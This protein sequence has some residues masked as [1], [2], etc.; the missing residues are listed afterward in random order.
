MES[1]FP[2]IEEKIIKFWKDNRIFGKSLEKKGGDFVFYEGPP[3]ANG[4]P[5]VHHVLARTFKDVICRYQTM[6]GKRVLRKAGWDVHSLPV[7]LEVEKQLGL[8]DKKK[9]EEYGIAKFNQECKKSVWKYAT[10]WKDLTERIGYWLDLENPY[11]TSDPYYMES[12]FNIIKRIWGKGLLYQGYK[13]VPYCPRCGTGLSS[14]EVAQGYK[15]IKEDSIYVK[16]PVK[17]EKNTYLLVWTTTPWTLPSNVAIA[18]NPKIDYIKIKKDEEFLILAKQRQ[19]ILGENFEVVEKLRGKDLIGLNY[20]PLFDKGVVSIET[21][22][23][24]IYQI[25]SADFVTTEEGTGLVHIAPAFGQD[26]MELIKAQNEKSK[27]QNKRKSNNTSEFP[28]LLTVDEAGKFK[29]EVKEWAGLFVKDADPLIIKHLAQEG[30]LF[31]VER[32]EH[33]YP[34]CWRCDT[35]LLYYAKKSWFIKTTDIKKNLIANNQKINWVPSHIKD[36]RFGE[37]LNDLKDWAISRE[38]YWGTPLPIWKCQN[39]DEEIVIGSRD[40][41]KK[42]KTTTNKYFV[43]RHGEAFSNAENFFS[44]WPELKKVPLTPKGEASIEQITSTIKGKKIDIIISSDILRA[45][46]TAQIVNKELGIGIIY[47]ERLRENNTGS[48]NGNSVE[49]GEK[50]F[51]PENKLTYEQ[52]ILSKFKNS[53][54]GGENYSDI[55]LRMIDFINDINKKYEN[56]NILIVSHE[57]P[58]MMLESIFSGWT[59]KEA[60]ERREEI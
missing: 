34:F 5:G 6:K 9:I 20:N 10:E 48:L 27:T 52:I 42:K 26:D 23:K 57:V 8:K 19:A 46:Q 59:N 3:T 13:V 40:D 2:K 51:N 14:H 32:Y 7:E 25:L 47:D 35:P 44:S 1:I 24:N 28:I 12:V 21:E 29:S 33:E 58:I 55:K 39:C 43:L 22:G 41:L 36:G 38:R 31:K 56:K 16:F 15:T 37:W 45:S 60:V 54:P 49:E 18:V 17:N 53:F 4:K 11:V 30:L 50:Y